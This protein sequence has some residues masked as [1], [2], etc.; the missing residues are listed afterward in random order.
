VE[1]DTRRFTKS[2]EYG[3]SVS[4]GPQIILN[5][6]LVNYQCSPCHDEQPEFNVKTTGNVLSLLFTTPQPN[7]FGYIRLGVMF[8]TD[9]TK[10]YP[11]NVYTQ[12]PTAISVANPNYTN[13]GPTSTTINS[14]Q[15]V[16]GFGISG[17]GFYVEIT[18]Y[19][20]SPGIYMSHDFFSSVIGYRLE[21]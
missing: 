19:G 15:R 1:A 10:L 3:Q 8:R 6:D 18:G 17:H 12:D 4:V 16:I 9:E 11:T 5:P 13:A 2:A 20:S 14:T 7:A 21:L